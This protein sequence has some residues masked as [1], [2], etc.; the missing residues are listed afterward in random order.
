M[1][2]ALAEQRPL[3]ITV[4]IEAEQRVV[5]GAFEMAV[6]GGSFLVA[7]CRAYR[8]VQIENQLFRW[9]LPTH[10]INPRSR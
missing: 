4:L 8:R 1:D 10:L 7:V 2:V 3:Q 9:F 6:V 5:A